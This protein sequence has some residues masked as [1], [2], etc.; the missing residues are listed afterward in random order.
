MSFGNTTGPSG[1]ITN[2]KITIN[3]NASVLVSFTMRLRYFGTNNSFPTLVVFGQ[4][5]PGNPGIIATF[6]EGGLRPANYCTS[7]NAGLTF[8]TSTGLSI[9]NS[10]QS[11]GVMADSPIY[12][13]LG[14]SNTTVLNSASLTICTGTPSSFSYDMARSNLNVPGLRYDAGTFY[15]TSIY[16]DEFGQEQ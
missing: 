4:T 14:W 8:A 13:L 6:K 15:Y 5:C 10:T 16:R 9:L 2:L 11:N 12:L 3:V 1:P 7:M